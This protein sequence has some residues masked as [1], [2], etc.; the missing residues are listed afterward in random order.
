[1][2]CKTFI[3]SEVKRLLDKQQA[4]DP[5]SNEYFTVMRNLETLLQLEELY[6]AAVNIVSG[7]DAHD[8]EPAKVV[9]FPGVDTSH[10]EQ[11]AEIAE[12]SETKDTKEYKLEEV[13][14]ALVDARRNKGVNVT[15][16]L[17][18]FGVEHFSAFPAGK[19][20]ELMDRL[21]KV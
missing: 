8:I 9:E 18:E 2:E 16:L 14:A 3:S 6:E 10:F 12:S 13:R 4:L 5:S 19:Y 1:M 7:E 21:E 20:G 15:E 17:K 11:T